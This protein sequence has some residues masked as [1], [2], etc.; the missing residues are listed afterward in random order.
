MVHWFVAIC[1]SAR[2]IIAVCWYMWPNP[3]KKKTET[4]M[5]IH[6]FPGTC[7]LRVSLSLSWFKVHFHKMQFNVA[8]FQPKMIATILHFL[9]KKKSLL[10]VL[11]AGFYVK[12]SWKSE[13]H[14]AGTVFVLVILETGN[15][16]KKADTAQSNSCN[17]T[18]S[19]ARRW[20]I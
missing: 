11:T 9:H 6:P 1:F 7:R 5:C 4:I 16:W 17:N 20:R 14:T 2:L 3:G 10:S 18:G 8:F 12:F 15:N 19:F 13:S